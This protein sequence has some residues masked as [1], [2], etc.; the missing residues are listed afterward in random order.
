MLYLAIYTIHVDCVAL[1][2]LLALVALGLP[3]C[4]IAMYYGMGMLSILVTM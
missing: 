3:C 2:A 1:V 4:A